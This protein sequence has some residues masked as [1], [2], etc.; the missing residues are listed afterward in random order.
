MRDF[1]VV[2]PSSETGDLAR[3]IERLFADLENAL[4]ACALGECRPAL[5]V[6]ETDEAI[7][8]VVDLPGVDPSAVRVL[9]RS[10]LLV[11]AG[12]K[13]RSDEQLRT[14]PH[15]HLVERVFGRFARVVRVEGAFDGARARARLSGGELRVVLPKIH[16]RRGRSVLVPVEAA[17]SAGEP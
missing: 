10:D 12:H 9:L 2:L 15:F 16:E 5:D 4:G 8:L 1:H 13:P 17:D 14:L 7:E 6:V 11:V 3:E